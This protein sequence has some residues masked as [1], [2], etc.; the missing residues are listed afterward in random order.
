MVHSVAFV[1][2]MQGG[3]K[4][5]HGAAPSQTPSQHSSSPPYAVGHPIAPPARKQQPECHHTF[6]SPI[7][8]STNDSQPG[9]KNFDIKPEVAAKL[10]TIP[11]PLDVLEK[12]RAAIASA[13]RATAAARVA[14]ELVNVN[15]GAMK[16]E[17]GGQASEC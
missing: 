3:P 8:N 11:P 9:P 4:V 15:L 10:D 12:A 2:D 1:C 7:S 14:A 17:G 5:V 6:S 13:K 16:L